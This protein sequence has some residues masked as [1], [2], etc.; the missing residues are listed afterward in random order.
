[1]SKRGTAVLDAPEQD[2]APE[3]AAPR[4]SSVTPKRKLRR[5]FTEDFADEW[6]D[7]L[8]GDDIPVARPRG[9]RLKF[10][11][12][13]P[14]TKWGRIAAGVAALACMGVCALAGMATRNWLMHDARFV[15]PSASAIEFVGNVHATRDQLL[16][17]FGEDVE[18]NIFYVPLAERRAELEQIP[19]VAHATVMRL[20]PNHL[21]VSVVERTPVAFVRNGS[22]IGLVDANGVLLGMPPGANGDAHYSFPV[23]TGISASDPLS[24]RAARM[25]IFEQFTSELQ[26]GGDKAL[27]GISEVDL[28]SPEDLKALIST[29]GS[30]ILVHFGEDHFLE[31]YQKFEEHLPEWRTLYP[32]LASVDMRYDTQAVLEMQPGTAQDAGAAAPAPS[33]AA[34]AS[35]PVAPAVPEKAE[36]HATTHPEA[37]VVHAP[38]R[39][40]A[41]HPVVRNTVAKSGAK[42]SKSV[43]A[44]SEV[45][46]S[47][48]AKKAGAKPRAHAPAKKTKGHAA[49]KRTAAAHKKHSSQAVQR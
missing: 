33:A 34:P 13:L 7:P 31:R 20:L 12:G 45:A 49:A 22:R 18:R 6:G 28:S 43:K 42:S 24:T 40:A 10:R 48:P 38:V 2:Y 14:R 3:T 17:V 41:K 44:V 1:M 32:K 36:T 8:G 29:D 15:V 35:T 25:K 11:W 23:V 37:K 9:L 16:N 21:R 4:R 46:Y 30:D 26:G 47:V 39:H 27:N 19:W 5:D